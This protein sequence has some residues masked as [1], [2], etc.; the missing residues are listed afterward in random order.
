MNS[1]LL[2]AAAALAWGMHDFLAR[3]PSRGIGPTATVLA[4]TAAG[5]IVLSVVLLVSGA[6]LEIVWP[7]LWLVAVTGVFFALATLSLFSALALGPISIVCPIAGSYPALAVLFAVAG[8]ARPGLLDWLTIAAVMLGVAA[9]SQSGSRHDAGGGDQ[10]GRLATILALSFFASI[11]F[12]V[13]LTSGQAATPVFGNIETAWLARIFGLIAIGALFILPGVKRRL[14][15]AW[16]P[17]LGLMGALDVT[18]LI[19]IVAAGSMP[20]PALATIASSA[21]GAVAVVLARLILKER[22]AP[23][24]GAGIVLIFAGVAILA[25]GAAA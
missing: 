23:L 21:F 12:A 5:F 7:K 18:A 13:S 17:L 19:L 2:G 24:Q 14:P 11:A 4:V 22:I 10:G 3:F 8:G 16:L 20:D 1:A 9:V 25:G 15:L 6:T